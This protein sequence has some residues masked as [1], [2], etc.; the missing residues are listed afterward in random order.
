[1]DSL[2][3]W[4]LEDLLNFSIRMNCWNPKTFGALAR[5]AYSPGM[6]STGTCITAFPGTEKN[7][8]RRDS[9]PKRVE[10]YDALY[11]RVLILAGDGTK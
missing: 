2:I 1:M 7:R 11:C 9:Q 8:H 3:L 4:R 5:M 6:A 10:R